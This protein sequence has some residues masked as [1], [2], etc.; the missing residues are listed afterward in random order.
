MPSQLAGQGA[1]IVA[2]DPPSQQDPPPPLFFS[3]EMKRGK[4][5]LFIRI[6]KGERQL[7]S[8]AQPPAVPTGATGFVGNPTTSENIVEN[9]SL[10]IT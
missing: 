3:S 6:R 8:H 2:R 4:K 7:F 5:E 1:F 9:L 10:A